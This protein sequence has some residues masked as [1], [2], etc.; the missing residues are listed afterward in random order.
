MFASDCYPRLAPGTITGLSWFTALSEE[1]S[2]NYGL[3]LD[4]ETD[5]AYIPD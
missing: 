1:N 3:V 5:K 2:E 4:S